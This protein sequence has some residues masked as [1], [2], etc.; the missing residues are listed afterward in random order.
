M[1]VRLWRKE[2][3]C[4]PFLGMQIGA[5]TMEKTVWRLLKQLK[6][7]LPF[8]PITSLA[9]GQSETKYRMILANTSPCSL[10]NI[11]N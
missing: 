6:L 5:V 10:K 8:H 7:E 4:V 11:H 3:P 2:N 9:N 1:L